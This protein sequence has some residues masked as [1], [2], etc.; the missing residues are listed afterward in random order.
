MTINCTQT[1]NPDTGEFAYI[2][3]SAGDYARASIWSPNGDYYT[4]TIIGHTGTTIQKKYKTLRGAKKF[5]S[6]LLHSDIVIT[7][8]LI[9][10]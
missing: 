7:S 2:M 6:T 3:S 1:Y 10:Q 5:C 4:A 8:T 9:L